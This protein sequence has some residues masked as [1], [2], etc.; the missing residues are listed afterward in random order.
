MA[1]SG[2]EIGVCPRLQVARRMFRS[3]TF[4]IGPVLCTHTR[5]YFA[6]V[7]VGRNGRATATTVTTPAMT[8]PS[9]VNFRSRG[10]R[11]IAA[12]CLI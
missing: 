11:R 5:R 2:I 10:I 6:A 1:S 7:A 12:G 3:P 4:N 8:T 9:A